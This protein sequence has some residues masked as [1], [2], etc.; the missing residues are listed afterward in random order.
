MARLPAAEQLERSLWRAVDHRAAL[1]PP[2]TTQLRAVQSLPTLPELRDSEVERGTC[3]APAL[4][5]KRAARRVQQLPAAGTRGGGGIR[6]HCRFALPFIHVYARFS[7]RLGA[8][9]SEATMRPNPR[10]RGGQGGA[11]LPGG[12][13]AGHLRGAGSLVSASIPGRRGLTV[14]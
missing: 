10:W 11:A 1:C 14:S 2:R 7:K 4:P 9:I 8:S 3:R 5:R 13:R 6:S 12:L